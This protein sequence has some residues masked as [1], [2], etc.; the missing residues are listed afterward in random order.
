VISLSAGP[1]NET[2][3]REAFIAE[4]STVTFGSR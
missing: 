3:E 2:E 1:V 4:E